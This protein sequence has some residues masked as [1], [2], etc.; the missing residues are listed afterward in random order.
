MA[1]TGKSAGSKVEVTE[2][3]I[4][5]HVGICAYGEG[6]ELVG[7]KYADKEIWRGAQA[8]ETVI[9]IDDTELMGGIKKEGGVKGLLW[10]LPGK[11]TQVLPQS[12]AARLGLTSSTCPA[13]RGLASFFLTGVAE[14]TESALQSMVKALSVQPSANKKGFYLA[15]NNPYLRPI[16]VRVRR[17]SIGL[18]A[19]R[20]RIQIEND[21]KGRAQYASNPAHIIYE[22][23]VN[24]AWGMGENPNVIDKA[25]FEAAALTLYNEQFGLCIQ[26]TRQSKIEEFIGE[27]LNHVQG[28]LFVNPATGKHTLK[29]LRGDYDEAL[30]PII[31][32]SNAVL[33]SY[34]RKAWG[35]LANEVTVTYTNAE[36]GETASVTS[37][38]LAGIAAEGAVISSGKNYYGVTSAR[39]AI[40]LAERDLAAA[41]NPIATC[42][43]VVSRQF[44]DTVSSDVV[45][46]S[47]P[48]YDIEQIIFRVSDV[49]KGPNSVTLSLYEDIFGLDSA[50][51]LES[52]DTAWVDPS[53]P[54]TPATYYNVGTAPA[55]MMAAALDLNDPSEL[56]YPEVLSCMS[57]GADSDDDISY[58][59]WSYVTDVNGTTRKKSLGTRPYYGTWITLDAMSA[60][61]S[62]LVASLP[63]LRGGAPEEG[64]FILIGMEADEYSEIAT[65]QSA[66]DDGYLLNRGMLDTVP[67]AWPVGTRCFIVQ[68]AAA[69][70]D[71]TRRSV[72]E[73]T[74][75]WIRTRT[76]AGLLPIEDAPQINVTLSPRP[77]RPNRPANV[78]V[79]GVG[80]GTVDATAATVL[81]VTW[82]NRNRVIES[83]Q[84]LKWTEASVAGESGQTA[85]IDVRNTSGGLIVSYGDL[86]GTSFSVPV[87]DL[88]LTDTVDVSVWAERSGYRSLQAATVRATVTPMPALIL[89]GDETGYL[90]LSGDQSGRILLS[91]DAQ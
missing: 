86:T 80:F 60:E 57:V 49:Q 4:S 65:V 14:V 13:F 41:V 79:N 84:A 2:Y 5:L 15:A 71:T 27:V 47:W 87:A 68:S 19:S 34:S 18:T 89:S 42:E 40:A 75:Y 33:T 12:L 88:G 37:Q 78:K 21:S 48:E 32:P 82:A 61:A 55:F 3:T 43:A 72:Y 26:W 53:Q 24:T 8:D 67:R 17:N 31:D 16:S 50:S 9:A 54:P 62:T 44:W 83:T 35:E 63:G 59:L 91:G 74:P 29:L 20:A 76:S 23:M 56:E 36:T 6:I 77:Y 90:K 70:A 45:K 52:D 46:L 7:V 81:S 64:D 28:A 25:S 39:R 10:W 85:R 51:Y 69:L 22:C 58:D 73:S 38:D 30:L 1:A 11:S 66:T